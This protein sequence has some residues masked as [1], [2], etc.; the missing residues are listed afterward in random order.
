MFPQC[1]PGEGREPR[2]DLSG[3]RHPGC[4]K[5]ENQRHYDCKCNNRQR[6]WSPRQ[7]ALTQ[8]KHASRNDANCENEEID[9]TELAGEFHGSFEEILPATGDA[10]EARQLGH[11]DGEHQ[12]REQRDAP[13]PGLF[14][15]QFELVRDVC[16]WG[17]GGRRDLCGSHAWTSG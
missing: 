12:C 11:D 8:Y 3:R 16:R 14:G 2:G 17:S 9:L 1:W 7:K 6:H 15:G 5:F 13:H 4:G 10:E